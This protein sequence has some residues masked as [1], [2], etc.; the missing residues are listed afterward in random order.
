MEISK[1]DMNT[2][3]QF[4]DNSFVDLLSVSSCVTLYSQFDVAFKAIVLSINLDVDTGHVCD[5]TIF[6]ML[7]REQIVGLYVL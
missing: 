1:R 3:F 2:Q 7:P 4:Q 5:I 6:I